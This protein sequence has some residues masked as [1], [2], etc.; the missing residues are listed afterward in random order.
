M[1]SNGARTYKCN[2]DNFI[3]SG[4]LYD[5][6]KNSTRNLNLV[7]GS[8]YRLEITAL[9]SDLAFGLLDSDHALDIM[10]DWLSDFIAITRIALEDRPQLLEKMGIVE[11]S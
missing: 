5:L 9:G 7:G 11:P 10:E 4:V 8:F 1:L 6:T 3:K 2:E